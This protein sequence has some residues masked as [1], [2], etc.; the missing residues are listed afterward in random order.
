ME[1]QSGGVPSFLIFC[2]VFRCELRGPAWAVGSYSIGLP[3]GGIFQNTFNKIS[4]IRGR[5]RVY[6][7]WGLSEMFTRYFGTKDAENC[8]KLQPF[9]KNA[10]I[11]GKATGCT[12]KYR[13][14]VKGREPSLL[15]KQRKGIMPCIVVK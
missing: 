12:S 11:I 2:Y 8:R 1:L 7:V 10:P 3:A 5:P 15:P 6:Y 9:L 4:R 13:H 14:E